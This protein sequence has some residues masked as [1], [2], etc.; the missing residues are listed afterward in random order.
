MGAVSGLVH[1]SGV[2]YSVGHNLKLFVEIIVE[3]VYCDEA[4]ADF[5][6]YGFGLACIEFFLKEKGISC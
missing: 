1:L 4:R 3:R 5:A 6:V 2:C